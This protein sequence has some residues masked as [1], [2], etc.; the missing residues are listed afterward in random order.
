MLFQ[1]RK[2]FVRLRNT[3]EDICDAF[4]EL[5]DLHI[6]S[7]GIKTINVQ[8]GSKEIGQIIHVTSG[9]QPNFTKLQEYFYMQIK[10]K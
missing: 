5:S 4:W 2:T 8:K 10:Q 7:N 3:N 9:V 6:D 1:T